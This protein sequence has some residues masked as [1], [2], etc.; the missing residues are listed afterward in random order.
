MTV[1][2]YL[3]GYTPSNPQITF[4]KAR[5]RKDANTPYYHAEYQTTPMYYL[6]EAMRLE[7]LK[8]Y[9]IL[10]DR[11]LAMDWLCG[12]DWN[13]L[14]KKGHA[15]CLLIISPED[16]ELLLPNTEQR[17]ICIFHIANRIQERW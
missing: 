14:I 15:K 17:E 13:Y 12:A 8:D 3:A 7:R 4:I 6:S 5:A 10:N 16:L 2:E 11:I 1:Y 9:I